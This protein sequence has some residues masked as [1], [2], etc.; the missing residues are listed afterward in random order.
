MLY[1]FAREISCSKLERRGLLSQ[2]LQKRLKK[3][4]EQSLDHSLS[5]YP[6]TNKQGN[7]LTR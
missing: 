6:A 7:P 4:P 3:I 5:A 2:D 1:T